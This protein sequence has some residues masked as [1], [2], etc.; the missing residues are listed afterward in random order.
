MNYSVVNEVNEYRGK[1]VAL[2][3]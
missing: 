1:I 2:Y 3:Y